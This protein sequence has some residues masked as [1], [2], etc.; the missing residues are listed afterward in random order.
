MLLVSWLIGAGI[1]FWLVK[2]YDRFEPEPLRCL[3]AVGLGGGLASGLLA[4]IGNGMAAAALGIEGGVAAVIEGT[5]S[6]AALPWLALFVGCNEEILKAAAAVLLTRRLGDLDE[7]ID[8]PLYAMMTALGFAVIE[9][10]EYASAFGHAVLLPRY[11]LATSVHVALAVIWGT[12]WARGHFLEPRKP[13]WR[14]MAPAVTVAAV[15]HALWDYA[16]FARFGPGIVVAVIGLVGTIAWA[17]SAKRAIAMETPF[18]EPGTCPRCRA[19]G[20][21]GSRFCA[22]CGGRMPSLYFRHCA[23]CAAS[24]PRSACFC[25]RCGVPVAGENRG[26]ERISGS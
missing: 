6:A 4:S 9:N 15:L 25:P 21:P 19:L 16:L 2:R 12:A 24:I 17:H 7:P 13:L 3:L 20:R 22:A 8:A 5:A 18:L 14:V 26:Q 11:L 10:L 23:G 1:W